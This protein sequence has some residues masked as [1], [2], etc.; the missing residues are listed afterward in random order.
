MLV[1]MWDKNN[2]MRFFQPHLTPFVD[3]SAFCLPKMAFA[4]ELLL[5]SLTQ[6]KWIYFPDLVQLKDLLPRM[7]LKPRKGAIAIDTLLINCS[8]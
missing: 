8:P 1:S 4:P 5:S 7:Q 6:C 2:Y 3:E